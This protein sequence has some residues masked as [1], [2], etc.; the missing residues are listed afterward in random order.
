[1]TNK[2]NLYNLKVKNGAKTARFLVDLKQPA[3]EIKAEPVKSSRTERVEAKLEK[4]AEVDY[5]KIL[6]EGIKLFTFKGFFPRKLRGRNDNSGAAPRN[7]IINQLLFFSLIKFLFLAAY[8]I[9]YLVGWLVMFV[10]RL[11]YFILAA[12]MRPLLA[13]L[14]YLLIKLAV[15]FNKFLK[16]VPA[17]IQSARV[18][19]VE[20]FVRLSGYARSRGAMT[21]RSRRSLAMTEIQPPLPP[22]SGGSKPP[23]V[24]GVAVFA[25]VLLAIIL[26]LKAFT[27]YKSL[28]DIRG[29]VLGESE[30]AMAN[31]AAGGQAA[32]EFDFT[33]AG[34]SFTKAGDNF[35]SAQ[36]QLEE[37]NSLIFKLAAI[38]PSQD[39]K[40]AA[41]G[42]RILKAGE[43]SARASENLSLALKSLF[44]FGNASAKEILTNLVAYGRL[45]VSNLNDLQIEL[46]QIDSE[47]L[48][49]N[50]Q[51]DFIVAKQKASLLSRSLNE[52]IGL[53]DSLRDFL[54]L[55][56]N[57]RY[58]LVFQN[59][60]ELR[61]SGGFIGSFAIVDFAQ[62]ELINIEAPGGG[63][64]DTDAGLLK[65][66]KSPEPLSLIRAD[67]HF[68]DANWWPDW[69]TS[70]RKLAW[71]YENSDGATVDG[72]ISLTPTVMERLL[73][74]IGPIDMRDKYGLVIDAD[75]FWLET[76]KLA[77]QK[78]NVTKEP[79]K[80][81]GDLMNKLLAELPKRLSQDNLVPLLKAV[82]QSLA[83]KN[84]LFYF[85][86]SA[87]QSQAEA[88]GWAG[89]ISD[90]S[91]DYLN[92]VNTNI[93]GGKSDR[94]IKQ[95]IIHQAQVRSDG[96]IIDNLTVRRTHEAVKRE[97]FS[98][99]RNVNWLRI[100]VPLGAKLISASGF[101]PVDKIFF[102][103]IDET[104]QTDP[105]VYAAESQAQ[106]H[107]LSGLKIYSEFNKTVFAN[108]TQLDPG[109]TIEINLV[110]ELPFKLT[111]KKS[112]AAE[113]A[114]A[115]LFDRAGRVLNLEPE[116][117]Y[118]YS[119]LAQKQPGMN[120]S[121]ILS[122]LKLSDN[123]RQ[124]WKY[125]DGLTANQ[126]GWFMTANLDQDK[127]MAL[128]V[129]KN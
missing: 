50:Y 85:T 74:I 116:P 59:N 10:L 19:A 100:Y 7:D 17:D 126:R 47:A 26:P 83:D 119:L 23:L 27:Y 115:W 91:G 32:A 121:T 39:I 61:A 110:Y 11:V 94:K 2:V 108:W 45:A 98:G 65:K 120:S 49:E 68:W 33:Q 84:I 86:D 43:L 63:S 117:L 3:V 102:K 18:V 97:P 92:V 73:K 51:P 35:L 29:K 40:L 46:Q 36:N 64:Y 20:A 69:P 30:S 99:V 125:P 14:N 37:I 1:M 62:G 106:T 13:G 55:S 76:Q 114:L 122:E 67:W 80:I 44:N 118:A 24:R 127:M 21:S 22:L 113:T 107:E 16:H 31:L 34:Q 6:K 9:C 58:L 66:I 4:L 48:P 8:K 82:E 78:P 112:M 95:Q 96:T 93:A 52:F 28:D 87:L 128:M 89:I 41:A 124:L 12:I 72:V 111:D 105:E 60:S 123:F 103:P 15:K 53:A 90:T 71:F 88:F 56:A 77:E 129:E 79:K 101:K 54:G 109:E 5:G 25:G 75:N 42:P 104:A 70:A 81:I 57:K 38:V